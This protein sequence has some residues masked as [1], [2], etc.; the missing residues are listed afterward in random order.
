MNEKTKYYFMSQSNFSKEDPDMLWYDDWE[1]I[2]NEARSI[3]VLNSD[4]KEIK[5]PKYYRNSK[6]PIVIIRTEELD[7]EGFVYKGYRSKERK[8]SFDIIGIPK[9]LAESNGMDKTGHNNYQK[10]VEICKEKQF[11][12]WRKR[13]MKRVDAK[14]AS[15]NQKEN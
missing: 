11:N 15:S 6:Q 13:F 2:Y 7:Y 3:T 4:Q 14:I 8:I 1:V 9:W 5:L 12:F 10:L